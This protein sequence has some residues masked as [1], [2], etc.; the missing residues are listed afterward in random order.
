MESR[1]Q[2]SRPSR[3]RTHKSPR[4]KTEF[5]KKGPFEAK[6]GMVEAKDK[7]HHF[8]LIM[9]GKFFIIFKRKVFKTLH[10]LKFLLIIQIV[11]SNATNAILKS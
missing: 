7:R 9:V 11:F 10:F 2:H 3:P 1:T 8:F 4:P 5:L 6:T